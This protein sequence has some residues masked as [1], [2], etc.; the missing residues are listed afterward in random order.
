MS[1][2]V[3]I[4]GAGIGGLS[5]AI[6]LASAGRQVV[7][8]EQNAAPGGKMGEFRQEGFRW[9]TGPSVIT[10]RPVLEDLFSSAGRNL[11]DYLELIAVEPLT[12]YFYPDGLRLD[13]TRDLPRMLAQIEKLDS[14]RCRRLL[15]L[16]GI[17]RPA[18]PYHRAGVHLRPAAYLK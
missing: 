17:R 18:A 7:V 5:A 11:Q 9:D 2:P 6:H 13:A 16:P 4:I 14:A 1:D 10:M 15:K 3:V 8:L 12:R